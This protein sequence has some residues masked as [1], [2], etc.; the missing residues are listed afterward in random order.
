MVLVLMVSLGESAVY[1]VLSIIER[2]T[3]DVPLSAQTSTINSSATP[4]RPWLDLA[5]Q[6]AYLALPLMPVALAIY[7]LSVHQRPAEGPWRVMGFDLR[8]PGF[9]LAWG[10][11]IFAGMGVVGL[12]FYLA[13]VAVGINTQVSPANL[14]ENWWTIPVLVLAAIKNGVLEEVLMIGF[15]FTRW[16]QTGARLWIIVVISALVRGSYHLYQGFGGFIG[17]L[18]MGL[19][20][21]WLFL[22]VLKRRVMAL[23]VTHSLLDIFAFL[24]AELLPTLMNWIGRG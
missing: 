22:T 11:G 7:L 1:A 4:D 2:L 12:A 5:Y 21:G 6:L 23:V 15:L 10:S 19:V 18:V 8:R 20:F 14:A 16:A 24:G 3:R 9:D 17:N 13:A